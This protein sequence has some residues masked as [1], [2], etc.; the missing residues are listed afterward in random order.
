MTS[1]FKADVLIPIPGKE[2]DS[3]FR[4][5]WYYSFPLQYMYLKFRGYRDGEREEL[6]L[7]LP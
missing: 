5:Q 3:L 2:K 7:P 4:D 1:N 6:L